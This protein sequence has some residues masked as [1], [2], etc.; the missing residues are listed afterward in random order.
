MITIKLQGFDKVISSLKQRMKDSGGNAQG[1]DKI[2]RAAASTLYADMKRRIHNEGK[3][4]SDEQ[5]GTY[6]ESYLKYRQYGFK[7]KKYVR[8]KNK[9]QDRGE[10]NKKPNRTSDPKVIISLTKQMENNMNIFPI[11]NGYGIGY[12][13]DDDFAKV[14]YVE[15]TYKKEIFSATDNELKEVQK[16]AEAYIR[17]VLKK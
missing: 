13:N 8:G 7:G 10:K 15:T 2:T 14:D 6:S 16:A 4:S 1:Q 5:I 9:G 12:S 17:T 3:D 11:P